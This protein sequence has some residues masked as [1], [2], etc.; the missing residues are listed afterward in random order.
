MKQA[1]QLTLI[2]VIISIISCQEHQNDSSPAII[3][4]GGDII[5]MQD[6]LPDYAE[7]VVV[8]DG[9]ILFVGSLTGAK[10]IGG[11]SSKYKDRS[12]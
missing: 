7:A 11:K 12:Y 2:L 8:R 6:D 4:G 10:K 5:T 3:Y 9:K 1:L